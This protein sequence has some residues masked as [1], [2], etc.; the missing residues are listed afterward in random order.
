MPDS[1]SSP[2]PMTDMEEFDRLF[3]SWP[4]SAPA[5]VALVLFV[6]GGL[7][8]LVLTIRSRAWFMTTVT[9]TAWLEALGYVFRLVFIEHPNMNVYIMMQCLLIITPVILPLVDYVV[10]G[11]LMM[12]GDPQHLSFRPVWVARLFFAS[13]ILTL[14]I[15]GAGGAMIS[16]TDLQT[17]DMGTSLMLIGLSLQLGFFTLFTCLALWMQHSAKFALKERANPKPQIFWCLYS[18]IA[19]MY[20]RNIFRVVE[21]VM[22]YDGALATHEEYLYGFDFVPIFLCVVIF[23]VYHYGFLLPEGAGG[24]PNGATAVQALKLL[25]KGSPR[26]E[27]N[28]LVQAAGPAN[29]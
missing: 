11:R 22:G 18:T 7:V 10:V 26:E 21:F 2:S 12:L 19:L 3:A 16:S 4:V 20:I 28:G 25:H 1:P 9:V 17:Q 6:L 23:C 29:V 27:A 24:R 15:Q 14:S 5:Y 13:D 8:C